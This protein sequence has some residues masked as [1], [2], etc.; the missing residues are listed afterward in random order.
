VKIIVAKLLNFLQETTLVG[1]SHYAVKSYGAVLALLFTAA[2]LGVEMV[3]T[4]DPGNDLAFLGDAK[5][6]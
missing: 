4:G 1:G 3:V 2:S 5:A 6:L